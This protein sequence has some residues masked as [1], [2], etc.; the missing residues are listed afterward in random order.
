MADEISIT[1]RMRVVKSSLEIEKRQR[2]DTWDMAGDAY[3][4]QVI[5]VATT[6][7]GV[8]ITMASAIGTPG[9]CYARN[10]D[11]T[12]YVDLGRQVGGTFYPMVKIQAGESV[13]FR[14]GC[15]NNELYARANTSAVLLAL[16]IV[17]A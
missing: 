10:L 5:S 11:A 6:A 8:A 13:L 7:A 1:T 15:A 12:N 4:D 3:M 14:L 2:T 9:W 17:E 16:T